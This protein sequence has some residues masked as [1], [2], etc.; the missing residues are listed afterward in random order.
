MDK[1]KEVETLR[2]LWPAL[3]GSITNVRKPCINK[4]CEACRRGDK[5]PA[6][7]FTYWDGKKKRCMYVPKTFVNELK[8]ALI[9]GR[10]LE[11]EMKKMGPYLIREY[12]RKRDTK[13]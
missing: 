7:I 8:K 9:N 12:R 5:H 1:K 10:K 11:K 2:Q 13:R 4:N 6:T 3:Q